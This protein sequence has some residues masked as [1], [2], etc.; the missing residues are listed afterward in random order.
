MQLHELIEERNKLLK[1]IDEE[2]YAAKVAIEAD[3]AP[4]LKVLE[5][6]IKRLKNDKR[7]VHIKRVKGMK[8]LMR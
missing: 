1:R 4:K 5:S 3:Y 7:G 2:T 8:H 6:Q